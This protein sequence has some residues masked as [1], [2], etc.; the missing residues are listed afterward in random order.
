MVKPIRYR[1]SKILY[2]VLK[3]MTHD[4]RQEVSRSRHHSYPGLTYLLSRLNGSGNHGSLSFR[5]ALPKAVHIAPTHA[6]VEHM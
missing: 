1:P 2:R 6:N 4:H 5:G 3:S